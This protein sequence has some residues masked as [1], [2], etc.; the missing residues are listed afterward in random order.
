MVD[1]SY[2]VSGLIL[3]SKKS[4]LLKFNALDEI[5]ELE[6]FLDTV[7]QVWCL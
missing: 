7:V 3:D 2:V 5:E 6:C 4:L 1:V